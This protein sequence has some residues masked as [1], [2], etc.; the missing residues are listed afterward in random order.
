MT[1]ELKA[2]LTRVLLTRP[3]EVS[4][5]RIILRNNPHKLYGNTL[6]EVVDDLA[7][8]VE[9]WMAA[10]PPFVGEGV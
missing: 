10:A 6:A 7:R 4:A 2:M 9:E 3:C 1:P 8:A 5:D